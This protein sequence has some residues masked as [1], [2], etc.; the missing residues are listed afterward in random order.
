M[1]YIGATVAA[2]AASAAKKRVIL[3]LRGKLATSH[4]RAAPFVP[5]QRGDERWLETLL[6]RGVVVEAASGRYWLNERTQR[7]Y[8]A[9]RMI[10]LL[11]GLLALAIGAVAL[12]VSLG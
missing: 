2:A 7:T 8:P 5:E 1:A 10:V 9:N 3:Q 12:G 6:D 4:D 11:L